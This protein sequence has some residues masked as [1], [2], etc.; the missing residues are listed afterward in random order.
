MHVEGDNNIFSPAVRPSYFSAG[1]RLLF[2]GVQSARHLYY[3]DVFAASCCSVFNIEYF[4]L[5]TGK[6]LWENDSDSFSGILRKN[7]EGWHKF[8]QRKVKIIC[9]N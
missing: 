2:D 4:S 9:S 5:K 6:Y 8:S 7:N 3:V 1:R